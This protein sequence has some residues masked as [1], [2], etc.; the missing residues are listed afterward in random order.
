MERQSV[1]RFF[2]EKL[3]DADYRRE[4]EALG[5]EYSTVWKRARA[6]VDNS[7]MSRT[8]DFMERL[9]CWNSALMDQMLQFAF[10][11]QIQSL[12]DNT[13]PDSAVVEISPAYQSTVSAEYGKPTVSA[14]AQYNV[15][16]S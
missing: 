6:A 7:R 14:Q 10:V 11:K 9:S 5:D 16:I 8:M 15:G 12:C 1:T 2:A 4:Y 3:E 13:A